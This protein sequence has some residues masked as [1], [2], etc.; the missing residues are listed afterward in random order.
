[1][2]LTERPNLDAVH[3]L[4]SIPLDQF[5]DDCI[6]EAE[7]RGDKKPT[8]KDIKT[9]HTIL[10]QFCKTNIKTKGVT[11]RVY[12]YSQRTPAGLGGRLFCSGSMQS[13]WS[14][15]RGLL[16]RDRGTD[17]D[18][19][20][21]HPVILRYICKLHHIPCPQ[22]D[23]FIQNR[24]RCLAEFNSRDEGKRAY[25]SV[26]NNDRYAKIKNQPSLFSRFD[27]EMGWIQRQVI[28]IPEY[29]Q[30]IQTVP[31][32]RELNNFNGSAINRILC[33]YENIILGHA[34]HIINTRGLEIAILMFDGLMIYGDHY[35]DSSLLQEIQDYVEQMMPGLNMK[36]AYKPHDNTLTIPEDF[37]TEIV[38]EYRHADDD[39]TAARMI[40]GDLKDRLKY[41]MNRIFIKTDTIWICDEEK[42]RNYIFIFTLQSNIKKVN[43]KGEWT[44]Y[45]QNNRAAKAIT[46]IV[47]G[48]LKKESVSDDEFYK[49][50]RETTVGRI[51]F[52][53]GVLDFAAS[54]FYT[55][56][57]VDF[58]YYTTV[59]INS[60]FADY[61]KNPDRKLSNHIRETVFIPLF[62]EDPIA[63]QFLARAIAGHADDKVWATLLGKR[64]NGKGVVYEGLSAAFGD[65]V[66]SFE[67][68]NIMYQRK[69]EDINESSRKNAWML[70]LEFARL[71][72]SQEIPDSKSGLL[73]NGKKF[74]KLQSGGDIQIARRNYAVYD[75]YFTL[76]TTFAI[77]GNNQIMADDADVF[78]KCLQF[79]T[80]LQFKTQ[81]EIDFMREEYRDTPLMLEGLRV[82]N[83]ELKS[84]MRTREWANAIII[85]LFD[86]YNKSAV[87]I[88]NKVED[89]E[90]D[91]LR[92]KILQTY[93]ITRN[94]KDLI[95]V[96][97]V[98]DRMDETLRK[99]SNELAGIGIQK[100][101]PQSGE[102]R[103]VTCFIGLRPITE[104]AVGD[105]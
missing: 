105:A 33:Y 59:M 5:R 44:S 66:R 83:P 55:W 68:E 67:L 15:Y 99:I 14:V 51:C 16:M 31:D 92:M 54:R 28:A 49:K 34:I 19:S 71:A 7:S 25:L 42:I 94:P 3:Y 97:T 89:T 52:K 24:D 35:T 96:K 90:S 65:Y 77:L 73:L 82:G 21:A 103:R 12:S 36:W 20:N 4:N 72:I 18:M 32:S 50:L 80:A 75:T 61:F 79:N 11:K 38:D 57:D 87:D 104:N 27:D 45:A 13:I 26:V 9:W 95:P 1:M 40:M 56:D 2:E 88:Q 60:E 22:L 62:G 6:S 98:A 58:E 84:N 10:Q 102:Y 78:E 93:E 47:I 48:T 81:G 63:L 43:A 76:Q 23:Y 64:N 86:N 74:K 37:E 100:T 85:L 30:I 17:I 70:D 101:F 41:S 46:E 39:E 8:S 29:H 91:S 69:R 53:D